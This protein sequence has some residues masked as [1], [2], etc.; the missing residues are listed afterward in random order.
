[1]KMSK[2]LNQ[3][4]IRRK[5]YVLVIMAVL[6]L[7]VLS[8]F[9][10]TILHENLFDSQ[11]N[12]ARNS[13]ELAINVVQHYKQLTDE[14]LLSQEQAQTLAKKALAKM[15]YNNGQD[16]YS[17]YDYNGSMV[18]H[19]IKPELIGKNI[20][21]LKDPTGKAFMRE[22]IQLARENKPG[23]V[24]YL[25]PKPNS[26]TDQPVAKIA[27]VQAFPDWGWIVA[28]G[29]YMDD[30]NQ[31]FRKALFS[32]I[33]E[34]GVGAI[35][36][37]FIGL[38]IA[39]NIIRPIHKL[40]YVMSDIEKTGDLTLR[41]HF[42]GNDEVSQMAASFN[43][44]LDNFD[45]IIFN[46]LKNVQTVNVVTQQLVGYSNEIKNSSQE[47]SESSMSTAAAVEEV[48]SSIHA[49][50]HN[51]REVRE[52]SQDSVV[53][54]R[55]GLE[56]LTAL[57]EKMKLVETSI[58]HQIGDT[59][60]ALMQDMGQINQMTQEVKDIA[61]QTNLLALN[62]AIEA[63]RAGE[64][65]RGFAVVADEVRKLAEK[66]ALSANQI[67]SVTQKLEKQSDLVQEALDEGKQYIFDSQNAAKSVEDVLNNAEN[68]SSKANHGIENISL[69]VRQQS[70]AAGQIASNIE[71]IAHMAEK[72][73]H[74]VM[75]VVHEIEGL[76]QI[77]ETLKQQ[78]SQFKTRGI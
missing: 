7:I 78:V 30:V 53:H 75:Q 26:G 38:N 22:I 29:I 56:N 60:S 17:L 41:L 57:L 54:T 65:G 23:F 33:I 2:W 36:L 43:Q 58:I 21:D 14:K 37:L 63:A 8:I 76:R 4:S 28:S 64:S 6:G 51:A 47:Q 72:N 71:T 74:D 5:L 20:I 13:T 66:S 77:A 27:Y 49:V 44:L 16:Y 31:N 24:E 70:E 9:Q 40:R 39:Q 55:S 42:H 25:W 19:P 15:R 62:A 35:I 73:N 69:S 1:M 10:L 48:T 50:S 45:S 11:K 18:M 68:Y 3:F 46:V 32:T 67:E 34:I 52:I 59:I 12:E 61:E